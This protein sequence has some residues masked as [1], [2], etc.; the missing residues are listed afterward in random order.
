MKIYFLFFLLILLSLLLLSS[1]QK[2]VCPDAWI[3]DTQPCV[4]DKDPSVCEKH[5]YFI[6]N[7]E[8]REMSDFDIDWIEKHCLIEPTI[9]S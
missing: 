3:V 6:F 4:Y 1:C 5:G 9:V 2:Q 7:H 8:R